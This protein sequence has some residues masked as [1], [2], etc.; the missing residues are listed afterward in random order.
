LVTHQP[1]GA[2]GTYGTFALVIGLLF[3]VSL[4][5]QL[6]LLTLELD[7]VPANWLTTSDPPEQC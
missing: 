7:V 6:L 5:A 4:L 1:E 2:S 3:P